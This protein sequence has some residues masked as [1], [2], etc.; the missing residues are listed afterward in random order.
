M[1]ILREIL[2]KI[3]VKTDGK[4]FKKVEEQLDAAKEKAGPLMDRLGGIGEKLDEIATGLFAAGIAGGGALLTGIV[5]TNAQFQKLE[6]NLLTAT[7]SADKAADAMDKIKAFA[8][9]TPFDLQQAVDAFTKLSLLGLD[10]SERA[11]R[12][13]GN[14]AAALGK[15]LEQFIEAVADASTGEFERLKEFGIKAS[16]QGDVIAFTFKGQT[17]KIKNDAAS[18]Q[19]FLIGLG[20]KDFAGAMDRQMDTLGGSFAA[21]KQNGL[22]LA[23]AIGKGGLNDAIIEASA[24]LSE[25]I[26][27]SPEAVEAIGEKLG[28]AVL[29]AA[30]ALAY[31]AQNSDK[32][33]IAIA[34]L[35]GQL[36]V[37][38]VAAFASALA[39][40]AGTLPAIAIG[41]KGVGLAVAGALGPI[42]LI[43]GVLSAVITTMIA[44]RGPI[45]NF[46]DR[47]KDAD[48]AV[49][50]V[51]RIFDS[52]RQEV[53]PAFDEALEL[54]GSTLSD[55]G[56]MASKIFRPIFRI[57]V[58]LAPVVG[59]VVAMI[60][61]GAA[62]ISGVIL[63]AV[64]K[65]GE[66]VAAVIGWVAGAVETVIQFIEIL[67]GKLAEFGEGA[68]PKIFAAISSF[69][70]GDTF[71]TIRKELML[72]LDSF[73]GFFEDL[74]EL[75]GRIF[76]PVEDALNNAL[77]TIRD[78]IRQ[79]PADL[80]PDSLKSFAG[81]AGGRSVFEIA[82]EQRNAVLGSNA[83]FEALASQ[84]S[85]GNVLRQST[86][87]DTKI[88]QNITITSEP[89][90]TAS[91]LGR[92]FEKR[93][94]SAL[95]DAESTYR[96]FA[97]AAA[98]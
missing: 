29:K 42:G 4:G 31:L 95:D 86:R 67:A 27:L 41:I 96:E 68:I 32:A 35:L 50:D 2:I 25:M 39:S 78:V 77:E 56:D 48:S 73:F 34:A 18:I 52:F 20:E 51:A 90:A 14:T 6:A 60:A 55:I 63:A 74:A 49:G 19:E 45:G 23:L 53:A 69:F 82:S 33:A 26:A 66:P 62:R 40:A 58:R 97:P 21:L 15:D 8:A 36:A 3:G 5:A 65:I 61:G 59:R 94:K 79:I 12:A 13:Y 76:K 47:F 81:M 54:I 89:N 98:Q 17:T 37:R 87:G 7:G 30:D 57:L 24:R 72:T 64:V 16:K 1:S 10:P 93:Q 9:T 70:E 28:D 85:S 38:K 92:E 75:A 80:L 83:M 11:L 84:A 71:K 46:I 44:L 22:E 43:V 88:D 91:E